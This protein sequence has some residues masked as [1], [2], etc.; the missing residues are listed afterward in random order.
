ML[1]EIDIRNFAVTEHVRIRFTAGFNAI[2][3]E[4]GA[5]KSIIIDALGLL[6]GERADPGLIRAGTSSARVEG[7]FRI[8]DTPDT[9]LSETLA[10][11]GIEPEDGL[12]IVS[13][14]VPRQG[15]SVAR[16][17]GRAVVQSTLS[18]LGRRLVDIH[19]QTDQLSILR[20]SEHLGYL[21]R[22]AGLFDQ[23]ATVA[24]LV[25]ELRDV[26]AAIRSIH[27]DEREHARRQDRLQYE[28]Q[29]IDDAQLRAGEEDDLRA[30]RQL[31]AN[32]EELARLSDA[33]HAALTEGGRT[34]SAVDALGVAAEALAQL[35]R[36]DERL[37]ETATLAESLQSQAYDLARDLRSYREG[38]EYNPSRL[39]QIEERLGLLAALRRKYG[40]TIADV[41]VYGERA[42]DELGE[43]LSSDE[44][45]AQLQSREQELVS[46]LG[47]EAEKLSR[48]RREAA[49]LLV[50]AV[51]RE[52]A[53]LRL[54]G[55]RFAVRMERHTD[56]NGTPVRLLPEDMVE[57]GAAELP[58]THELHASFDRT[59]VD[60]VEFYVSL[61]PGEPLRPLAK[62]ASGGETARLMLALKTILGAADAVPTLVF[63]EVDVGIGG[64]SGQ[65][66]GEKL[67]ALGAH[68]QVVCITHLP[69]VAARAGNHL[70]VVKQV[71]DGRTYTD[72]RELAGLDRTH[73]L[74]AM[75]GGLT[76]SHIAA[77][78]EMLNSV[79]NSELHTAG[80]KTPTAKR[81]TPTPGP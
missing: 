18:A 66:V 43:L 1:E 60:R 28:V 59:G 42:R 63:D 78:A 56:P 14:E 37:G 15:R 71:E 65:V 48:A 50:N 10:E 32:A 52:I 75:L 5:G 58:N 4:T 53:D 55:G 61:N 20:P 47:A 16:I 6:L 26:R 23:R 12:L 11:A 38:V 81:R 57:A 30:E 17:N 29:E 49:A 24:A 36:L 77:A 25:A 62:V 67:A 9:P 54:D 76:D 73:E 22:F 35:A 21:D 3:G 31:L 7:L 68:H 72:V 13:R 34:A 69:Q 40:D 79:P 8:A 64:R 19:G 41:I 46:D 44:R 45:L 51:Q 70:V 39:Q 27:E 80:R 74:A 33:A 2:T